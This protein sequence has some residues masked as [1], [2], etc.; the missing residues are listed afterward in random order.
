[1][2]FNYFEHSFFLLQGIFVG[3]G[4]NDLWRILNLPGNKEPLTM[5]PI[6]EIDKD[7]A[8]QYAVDAAVALS[9]LLLP[10]F[11][12]P[13][14]NALLGAGMAVGTKWSNTTERGSS[15]SILDIQKN[16]ENE[17]QRAMQAGIV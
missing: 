9:G 12:K 5:T 2:K 14:N 11:G 1:M 7:E 6:G 17:T 3:I 13:T 16:K 4:L 8:Y 15:L 10:L